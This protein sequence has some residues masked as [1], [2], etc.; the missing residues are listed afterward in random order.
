METAGAET[1]AAGAGRT[2]AAAADADDT[3]LIAAA[4]E[5]AQRL[6]YREIKLDT[7]PQMQ[8]AIALYEQCGFAPIAPYGSH[9][10]PGLVCLGKMI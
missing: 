2:A 10:Y 1:E 8:S 5:A 3:A 9:P 6:G 7:L 4:I